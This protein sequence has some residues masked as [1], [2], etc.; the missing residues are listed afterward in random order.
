MGLMID[1]STSVLHG[2]IPSSPKTLSHTCTGANT[3][4][5][6]CLSWGTSGAITVTGVT[7]NGVSMTSGRSDVNGNSRSDI[8]YLANPAAGAN[9]ISV[10]WTGTAIEFAI[11]SISFT[12]AAQTGIPDANNGSTG[13]AAPSTTLTPATEQCYIIDCISNT[14][15][16]VATSGQTIRAQIAGTSL[17]A[18][19]A[20]RGPVDKTLYTDSYSGVGTYAQSVISIPKLSGSD[21]SFKINSLRPRAFAPGLAR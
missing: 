2:S 16:V 6:V 3:M 21:P 20:T 5:S 13:T 19:M 17:R 7:Y 15:A 18:S 11:M 14:T 4:L 1:Y 9:T 8:Y 10:A 12:G